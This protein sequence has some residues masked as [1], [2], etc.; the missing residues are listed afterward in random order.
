MNLSPKQLP[1]TKKRRRR[2]RR[3]EKKRGREN[4]RIYYA[5]GTSCLSEGRCSSSLSLGGEKSHHSRGASS[6]SLSHSISPFLLPLSPSLSVTNTH[7]QPEL[8]SL[9]LLTPWPKFLY[10]ITVTA[11]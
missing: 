5:S 6:L 4:P 1:E 9:V 7:Q 11:A 2:K 8:V 3:E 10:H